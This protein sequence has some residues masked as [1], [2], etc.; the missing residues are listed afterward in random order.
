[1]L[2][3]KDS[4]NQRNSE[5]CT[6]MERLL[7]ER[8]YMTRHWGESSCELLL[9]SQWKLKGRCYKKNERSSLEL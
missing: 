9:S 5:T 7:D 3:N 8:H 2:S 4:R 1:M 6:G